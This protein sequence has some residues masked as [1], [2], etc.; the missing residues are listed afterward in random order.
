MPFALL[1]MLGP[2]Q[3]TNKKGRLGLKYY[4][5][6]HPHASIMEF[7]G[8]NKCNMLPEVVFPLQSKGKKVLAEVIKDCINHIHLRFSTVGFFF[9]DCTSFKCLTNQSTQKLQAAVYCSCSEPVCILCCSN[10]KLLLLWEHTSPNLIGI[11]KLVH[12]S[13]LHF[14]I[15]IL[16]LPKRFTPPFRAHQ[17]FRS[18]S[19]Y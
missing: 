1:Q 19:S 5:L 15:C 4:S 18:T 13:P 2:S 8:L 12:Y 3:K 10:T 6:L 11:T 9:S 16:T 17:C 7:V 14:I